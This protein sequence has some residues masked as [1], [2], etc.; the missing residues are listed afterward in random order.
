MAH[1]DMDEMY[2]WLYAADNWRYAANNPNR[3]SRKGENQMQTQQTQEQT[4]EQTEEQ[5][6]DQNVLTPKEET[7][8]QAL[9]SHATLKQAAAAAGIS[10][11]TLWRWLRKDHFR[12][13]YLEA[14][15][16]VVHQSFSRF[17][18]LA[19]DAPAVV[20]D[21]MNNDKE[22]GPTR[23]AAAKMIVD[24]ARKGVELEDTDERLAEVETMLRDLQEAQKNAA[25]R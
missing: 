4:E 2:A 1:M 3:L 22:S 24:N 19:A 12:K 21:I 20:Y 13:A 11:A 16:S 17:Q 10:D 15:R 5:T 18:Q 9:L 7:T 6:D 14:R 25:V 8:I 23:I